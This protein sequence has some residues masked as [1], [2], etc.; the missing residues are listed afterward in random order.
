MQKPINTLDSSDL[1]TVKETAQKSNGEDLVRTYIR[2]RLLGKGGFASVYEFICQE[3]KESYACK[4]I[5]KTCLQKPRARQKLLFEIK[6]HRAMHHCH[7]VEFLRFFEDATNIYVLLELCQ[8]E[9]LCELLKRRK[10]LTELEVQSYLAQMVSALKYLHGH[11][12]IH[13]DIKLGNLFLND[14][15]EIKLGDFGLATRLEFEG[16]RKSTIC[17]TP[18]YIAPEIIDGQIGHSYEVDIWSLGVLVYT[19]SVGKPPFETPDIRQTYRKIRSCAYSF[20]GSPKLSCEIKDLISNLIVSDPASRLSLDKILYHP[21]MTRN[22]IPRTLSTS[23]LA[24]PPKSSYLK[25]FQPKKDNQKSLDLIKMISGS[26]SYFSTNHLTN[27]SLP[28]SSTLESPLLQRDSISSSSSSTTSSS[29]KLAIVSYYSPLPNTSKIFVKKWV[30]YSS[31]YGLG[32]VLSNNFVGVYFNDHSKFVCNTK[33][34]FQVI[35]K[36]KSEEVTQVFKLSE[37]PEELRKKITILE[38]FRKYLSCEPVQGASANEFVYVKKWL[39]TEQATIFRLS[40]KTVHVRF[41]D[42]TEVVLSSGIKT[43]AFLDKNGKCE[44]YPLKSVMQS[45]NKEMVKRISYTTEL[46]SK[47]LAQKK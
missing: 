36:V 8:N 28:A 42:L 9:T 17:G 11:R 14:K 5:N 47:M 4:V 27:K 21:F 40:D 43:V 22:P 13:R 35:H 1:I 19:L 38:H 39:Q 24:I 33:G 10:R 32:Y 26:N 12:V 44:V 25:Q 37:Y 46:I 16:E 34:E 30:D 45:E 3:T 23:T 31:K 18:N 20:P 6:I 29:R 7:I 15:M 2:G 41:M